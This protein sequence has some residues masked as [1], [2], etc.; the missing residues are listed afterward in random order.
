ML[1]HCPKNRRQR[2]NEEPEA[3]NFTG[4]NLGELVKLIDDG[5]ISSS[6][7]KKVLEE[8]FE[9]PKSP[10][11][12]PRFLRFRRFIPHQRPVLRL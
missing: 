1:L 3:I 6:I 5:K 9:N 10:I 12:L 11:R 8:M 7:A 2:E 4:E